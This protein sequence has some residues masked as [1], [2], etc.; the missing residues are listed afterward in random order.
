[1]ERGEKVERERERGGER[2][3]SRERERR[4]RVGAL[5]KR[6]LDTPGLR[7]FS[8]GITSQVK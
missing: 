7:S 1:M 6:R 3:K 8:S 2:E 5:M 4:E